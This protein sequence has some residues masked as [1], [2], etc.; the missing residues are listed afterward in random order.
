[1]YFFIFNFKFFALVIIS[2][3]RSRTE[4]K[5]T[6]TREKLE[7]Y[8]AIVVEEEEERKKWDDR[9]LEAEDGIEIMENSLDEARIIMEE[10]NQKHEAMVKIFM[11]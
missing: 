11:M 6:E 3:Q 2:L 8:E 1:M 5:L 9:G 4:E 10:S 7:E